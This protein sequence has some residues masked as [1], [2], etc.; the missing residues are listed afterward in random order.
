[1]EVRFV[2]DDGIQ[3]HPV[4]ELEQLLARDHGSSGSISPSVTKRPPRVLSE[5]FGFHPLAIGACMERNASTPFSSHT[6]KYS[7]GGPARA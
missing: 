6:G 5:V 1:M 3:Q 4:G 2:S 7:P